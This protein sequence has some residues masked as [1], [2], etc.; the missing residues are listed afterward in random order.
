M[1][2]TFAALLAAATALTGAPSGGAPEPVAAEQL[3]I[4]VN[5]SGERSAAETHSLSCDPA[6]GNHPRAEE[7]C[8]ALERIAASGEDPFAPVPG[9][10]MCTQIDGG[11]A[12]AEVSGTWRGERVEAEF[13]RQ[14][15]CEI[16]RWDRV[17]ALLDS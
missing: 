16:A 6:G 15:G 11:P 2:S 3:T 13:S 8:L 14:N 10:A 17:G 4:T 12:T 7:A 9:D 5:E 1:L